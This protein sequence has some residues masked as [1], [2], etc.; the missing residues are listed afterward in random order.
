MLNYAI[1]VHFFTHRPLDKLE[2]CSTFASSFF[3]VLD[4][5]VNIKDW[6]SGD[7]QFFHFK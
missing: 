5:K 7:N 2:K 1:K 4:F 3:M 6:L